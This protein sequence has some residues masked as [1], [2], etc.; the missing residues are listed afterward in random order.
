MADL[1][2]VKAVT[3]SVLRHRRVTNFRAETAEGTSG[4]LVAELMRGPTWQDGCQG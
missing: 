2:D 1:D 4:D 3:R